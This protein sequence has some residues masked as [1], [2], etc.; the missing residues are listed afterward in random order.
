MQRTPQNNDM[1]Q[2]HESNSNHNL[3]SIFNFTNIQSVRQLT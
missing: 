3:D 2:D 1:M